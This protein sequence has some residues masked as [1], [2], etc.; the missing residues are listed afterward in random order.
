MQLLELQNLEDI[1]YALTI[2]AH[3]V[4]GDVS[5]ITFFRHPYYESHRF[6]ELLD[7]LATAAGS[8]PPYTDMFK[9]DFST[10]SVQVVPE[11]L[12]TGGPRAFIIDQ[13]GRLSRS[14][15]QKHDR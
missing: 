6:P 8:P 4:N 14:H 5:E 9:G 11:D 2:R 13:L 1:S 10:A 15:D 12:W 7:V 3:Q